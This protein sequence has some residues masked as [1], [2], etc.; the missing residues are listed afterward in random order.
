MKN[1]EYYLIICFLYFDYQLFSV[2]DSKPYPLPT[3]Q[4]LKCLHISCYSSQA[5]LALNKVSI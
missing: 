5:C 2:R 3:Y 1:R 4:M